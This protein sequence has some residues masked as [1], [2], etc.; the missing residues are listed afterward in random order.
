V[1]AVIIGLLCVVMFMPT[2][3][4]IFYTYIFDIVK[5]LFVK[6]KYTT[7]AKH[8]KETIDSL[9][10]LKAI[11]ENGLLE[12]NG[13]TYG[14]VIKIGQKNFG[15]EDVYQQNIDIGYFANALKLL[16]LTQS[17]DLVKID[18]PINFDGFSKDVFAKIQK[19]NTEGEKIRNIKHGILRERIDQID[20]L[21]NVR[22]QYLYL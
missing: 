11:R 6:K 8:Q 4:G 19:A 3:D 7:V 1:F 12:F 14:R 17:A 9:V 10:G 20:R 15:I 2:Q 5:F 16:D 13:G 21:N 22:K 18:R